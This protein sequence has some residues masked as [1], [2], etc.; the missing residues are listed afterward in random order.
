MESEKLVS[1]SNAQMSSIVL[2]STQIQ[3]I[4][5]FFGENDL[6]KTISLLPGISSG[7]EGFSGLNVRGGS[8][9]QNLVLL[10][11]V[12]LYGITHML[13]LFSVFN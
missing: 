10:D 8:N 6:V 3:K 4:P 7:S 1:I 9:D 2:T 5:S 12:P 13:G 11:D